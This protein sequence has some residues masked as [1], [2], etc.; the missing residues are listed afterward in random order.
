M[1]GS[2]EMTAQAER[3][4]QPPKVDRLFKHG[5][6]LFAVFLALVPTVFMILTSLKSDEEYTYNKI[7]L[8]HALVLDHFDNVVF[9]SPFFAWIWGTGETAVRLY[10]PPR[11]VGQGRPGESREYW[12]W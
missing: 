11:E 9:Q 8:P 1:A 5:V 7:G 4:W 3:R 12:I 6:L 10:A 2:M